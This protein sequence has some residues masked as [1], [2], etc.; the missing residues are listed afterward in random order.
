MEDL[1]WGAARRNAIRA[2]SCYRK[3]DEDLDEMEDLIW[4]SANRNALRVNCMRS[5]R[6]EDEED[7]SYGRRT[8]RRREDEQDMIYR[9][10]KRN[11]AKWQDEF[12]ED[13]Q[14]MIWGS[15]ARAGIRAGISA[16]S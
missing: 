5:M 15:I 8:G 11:R 6:K 12:T 16:M 7:M 13:E 3:G 1:I 2:M 4:G 10:S 9:R 14:D